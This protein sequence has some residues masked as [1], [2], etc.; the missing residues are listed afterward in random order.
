MI[1]KYRVLIYCDLE[2]Q[3]PVLNNI[4]ATI[5][6]DIQECFNKLSIFAYDIIIMQ[7]YKE[8][9]NTCEII[10]CIRRITFIPILF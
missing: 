7:L 9:E 1:K 3:N 4:E 8:I 6:Y 5:I 2:M 10:S